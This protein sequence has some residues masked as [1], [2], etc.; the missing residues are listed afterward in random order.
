[1]PASGGGSPRG[2][3]QDA[4]G[5]PGRPRQDFALAVASAEP[6]PVT[7]SRRRYTPAAEGRAPR[8]QRTGHWSARADRRARALRTLPQEVE[9]PE[10]LTGRELLDFHAAVFGEPRGLDSALALADLGPAIDALATTCSRRS[11]RRWGAGPGCCC[12]PTMSR[13]C[14]GSG[15]RR[16]R[17]RRSAGPSIPSSPRASLAAGAIR[18]CTCCRPPWPRRRRRCPPRAPGRFCR[19]R[20]CTAPRTPRRRRGRSSC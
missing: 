4:V 7:T 20:T 8:G 17:F 11:G 14:A 9:V 1:M 6:G 13:T 2:G 19:P 16:A 18:P 10:G 5:P 12:R 15:S 3:D